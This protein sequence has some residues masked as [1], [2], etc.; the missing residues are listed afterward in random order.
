MLDHDNEFLIFLDQL[1][2]QTPEFEQKI[3]LVDR[4]LDFMNKLIELE[5]YRLEQSFKIHQ[6]EDEHSLKERELLDKFISDSRR[7]RN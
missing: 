3:Q 5:K 7:E 2:T 6:Q 4:K 1:I